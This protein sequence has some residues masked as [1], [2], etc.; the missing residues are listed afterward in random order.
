LSKYWKSKGQM[1]G[2]AQTRNALIRRLS[3][4][5]GCFNMPSESFTTQYCS[6]GTL[7][8]PGM[9]IT[10]YSNSQVLAKFT[11]V[12]I[13]RKSTFV[14]DLDVLLLSSALLGCFGTRMML[15]SLYSI[16]RAVVVKLICV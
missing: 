3:R 4:K 12:R 13:A 16:Q 10:L 9:F 14:T 2:H 8:S 11:L 1:M 7:S 6:C 15:L 5:G